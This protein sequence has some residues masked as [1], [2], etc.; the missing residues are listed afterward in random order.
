MVVCMVS[1]SLASVRLESAIVG[2]GLLA[3]HWFTSLHDG[4]NLFFAAGFNQTFDIAVKFQVYF[5]VFSKHVFSFAA[6]AGGSCR[7]E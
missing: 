2:H 1:M 7:M 4:Q 5:G 6:P 3:Q